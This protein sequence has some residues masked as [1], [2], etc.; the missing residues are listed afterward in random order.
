MSTRPPLL[1]DGS[2]K[3]TPSGHASASPESDAARPDAVRAEVGSS[4]DWAKTV[5]LIEAVVEAKDQSEAVMALVQCIAKQFPASSVRCGIGTTRLRR[6]YESRLG[7]LG[8]ASELFQTA[9]ESWDE[10]SPSLPTRPAVPTE[11]I[12][13]DEPKPSD[14]IRLNLDDDVGFGR[15]VLWIE[16]GPVTAADRTWLRRALPALRAI[17]WTQSG[18]V[19]AQLSRSLSRS[20]LSTRILLGFAGLVVVLLAIWPV[21]YRV[22]CTTLVRPKH[23]RIVSAP[24]D[25]TL[26]S[27]HVQPGDAVQR[28]DVLISLDGR[29]LRLELETVEAQIG[30]VLKER[31]VAMVGGRVA[32]SQQ[33]KLKIREL[34]RQRDLLLSRLDRL[35]VSSPIDGVIVLGDL[36]RSIGAPLETGQAVLEIAPLDEML[37]ELEIPEYEIGYV[38]R[39]TLVRVRLTAAEGDPIEQP[40]DTVY[41]SA[42]LRDDQN[43]FVA[44]LNVDNRAGTLRPGMRG[45]A[46]AYGPVRPWLWSMLRSGWEKSLWWI[47][48]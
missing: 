35:N 13:K 9:A 15:C 12:A 33:A 10:E 18:G 2:G 20:G 1:T 5:A 23:S 16:G 48:Y 30:Q 19:A 44:H 25:A 46:I 38:D 21:S 47:G 31:D 29:P 6:F 27:T 11:R 43:V 7:W 4:A 14:A 37:V 40:I 24:F 36:N 17:V 34:T 26:L 32:D 3:T 41:P 28:G 45:D 8:P 39:G 22:R 42:E